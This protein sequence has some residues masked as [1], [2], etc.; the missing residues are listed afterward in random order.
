M[1]LHD[2]TR[3]VVLDRC[4]QSKQAL[5]R[6]PLRIKA[7]PQVMSVAKVQRSAGL[8]R[9]LHDFRIQSQ[10]GL[11]LGY[12]HVGFNIRDACVAHLQTGH[13]SSGGKLWIVESPASL[14]GQSKSSGHP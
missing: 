8:H 10:L 9:S 6:Y 7:S 11:M 5:N 1:Y 3:S 4:I 14:G 13:L 12:V 2:A